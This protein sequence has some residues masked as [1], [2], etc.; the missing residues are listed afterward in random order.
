M[1]FSNSPHFCSVLP[2]IGCSPKENEEEKAK[3]CP[4]SCQLTPPRTEG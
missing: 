4:H 3:G 1:Q 2:S